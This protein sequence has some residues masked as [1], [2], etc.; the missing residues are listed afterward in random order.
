MHC[1]R[2]TKSELKIYIDNQN[3]LKCKA[4]VSVHNIPKSFMNFSW[5]CCS[6]IYSCLN[7]ISFGMVAHNLRYKGSVIA[8]YTL[9]NLLFVCIFYTFYEIV[10]S[11]LS[12]W[13]ASLWNEQVF[14]T[15]NSMKILLT[16]QKSENII[17][18]YF[19]LRFGVA[20]SINDYLR[21]KI[22]V[23]CL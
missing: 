10:L 8:Q 13:I 22:C 21:L 9:Y 3:S 15:F 23:V 4:K 14:S 7:C 16:N 6:A 1:I 12:Y 11:L 18:I 5:K 2:Q 20:N 17:C 19:W